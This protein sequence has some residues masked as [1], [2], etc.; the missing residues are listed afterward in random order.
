M[1]TVLT[2]M[3]SKHKHLSQYMMSLLRSISRI[4]VGGED[5][6]NKIIICFQLLTSIITKSKL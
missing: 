1:V 6:G 3:L 5:Y 2:I 4:V